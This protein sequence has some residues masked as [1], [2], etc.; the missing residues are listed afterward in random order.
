M[1]SSPALVTPSKADKRKRRSS[2]SEPEDSPIPSSKKAKS[3][4]KATPT[5][6]P[7]EQE[8]YRE[9]AEYQAT[10]VD[11]S[12]IEQMLTPVDQGN[13][14]D[15]SVWIF[16]NQCKPNTRFPPTLE[17]IHRTEAKDFYELRQDEL[18]TLPHKTFQTRYDPNKPGW[19]YCHFDVLR[20]VY[21]KEAMCAGVHREEGYD[22]SQLLRRGKALYIKRRKKM[23]KTTRLPKSP[24]VWRKSCG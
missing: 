22:P 3:P 10:W 6:S 21:R 1:S 2:T 23:A 16:N 15:W 11:R 14:T 8:A 9:Y 24:K 13:R 20:L 7:E 19:A 5:L 17:E 18:D 4:V 12:D